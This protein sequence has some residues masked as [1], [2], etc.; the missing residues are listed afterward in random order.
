M[1]FAFA[2]KG[3]SLMRTLI[4][5]LIP[6]SYGFYS[7]KILWKICVDKNGEIELI[8]QMKNESYQSI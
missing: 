5:V 6:S 3:I 8:D 1:N 2:L 7:Y 4:N